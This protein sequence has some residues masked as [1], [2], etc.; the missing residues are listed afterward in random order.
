MAQV[1][2]MLHKIMR[3]FDAQKSIHMQYRLSSLS[4]KWP[5]FMRLRKTRQPGTLPSNIVRNPKNYG[6]CI[7]INTQGCKKTIDP[8]MPSYEEKVIKDDD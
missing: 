4:C 7:A 8:P 2:D 1:E 5:K 3:R 6:H